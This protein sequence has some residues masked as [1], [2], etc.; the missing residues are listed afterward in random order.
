MSEQLARIEAKRAALAGAGTDPIAGQETP[1]GPSAFPAQSA[2]MA[3]ISASQAT[4]CKTE[5]DRAARRNM[6]P[7]P[8]TIG[9][10]PTKRRPLRRVSPR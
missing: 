7:R 3:A 5:M 8:R 1:G 2:R 6:K 4:S 10:F 9:S